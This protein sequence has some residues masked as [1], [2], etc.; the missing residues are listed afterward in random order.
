MTSG[1]LGSA[2]KSRRSSSTGTQ[3]PG[4]W[5]R[6][7]LPRSEGVG[8][9]HTSHTDDPSEDVGRGGWHHPLHTETTESFP[10]HYEM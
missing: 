8:E 9:V 6:S 7:D 5:V 1:I 4:P 3:T 10:L 2:E